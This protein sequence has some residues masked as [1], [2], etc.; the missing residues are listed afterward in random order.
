MSSGFI[1]TALMV[2]YSSLCFAMD[3][4]DTSIVNT[5]H[6]DHLYEKITID[7]KDMA[8]VHVYAEAP[9]YNWTEAKGEG[10]ACVDDVA[11]AAIFYLRYFNVTNN[12]AH[13]IKAKLLYEFLFYMQA[14]NGL[15]YNFI[16]KDHSI[17]K[18]GSNSKPLPN[19][20][21][22]RALWAMGE[23]YRH[24]Y[25]SDKDFSLRLQKSLIQGF[26]SLNEFL[27]R[28]PKKTEV[29]GFRLPI[30]LPYQYASDQAS[31]LV[32]ALLPFY[33][34]SKDTLV[35]HY[36]EKLSTGIMLMQA[37]DSVS[38]PYGAHLSW[39]N[40]WHAWGANQSEAL[41]TSGDALKSKNFKNSAK[42]EIDYFYNYLIENN[43]L[44]EFSVVND[45]PVNVSHFPQIAYGI[46]PMVQACLQASK[47]L[48]DPSYSEKGAKVAS[49]FFGL[50]PAGKAMYDAKSGRC[51]DGIVSKDKINL[52]SGAES[53]IEA[54]MALLAVEA[55]PQARKVLMEYYNE[56][57]KK[58]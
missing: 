10:I 38:F 54:L 14:E 8:I 2:I 55:N 37:G 46:N 18:E 58:K 50:N 11:R 12:A 57:I 29:K 30:W 25:E 4:V 49:W 53:T 17:N 6:L 39:E 1:L 51:Y 28:Y 43:Y 23:A 7:G 41:L 24:F 40:T 45:S 35:M 27:S 16:N 32:L 48:N 21:S 20:W 5:S 26:N 15:F 52:N 36:I 3:E 56:T 47:V 42:L 33:E 19:W 13:L 22:W 34:V 9:D 31:V 44:N